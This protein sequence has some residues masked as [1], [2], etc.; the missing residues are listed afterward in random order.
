MM[1]DLSSSVMA[2]N[3]GEFVHLSNLM[4]PAGPAARESADCMEY[5]DSKSITESFE[6]ASVTG[7]EANGDSTY[8]VNLKT[9]TLTSTKKMK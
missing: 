2:I 7:F 8:T 6:D 1:N 5:L 3:D 9:H 4:D